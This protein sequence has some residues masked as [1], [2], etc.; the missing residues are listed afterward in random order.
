MPYRFALTNDTFPLFDRIKNTALFR[1]SQNFVIQRQK[2]GLRARARLG[3]IIRQHLIG[4]FIR[5]AEKCADNQY[6]WKWEL[7]VMLK[8]LDDIGDQGCL[9]CWV[10]L[11]ISSVNDHCHGR[12][13]VARVHYG[14]INVNVHI[15]SRVYSLF[16]ISS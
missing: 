2:K 9:S 1:G 3:C 13:N 5:L 8:D 4:S 7:S 12:L 11:V 16:V 15:V 14:A 10:F 6:Q